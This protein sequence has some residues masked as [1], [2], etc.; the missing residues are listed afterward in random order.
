M[1]HPATL[2]W[3]AHDGGGARCARIAADTYLVRALCSTIPEAL[4]ALAHEAD[5]KSSAY[6]LRH[7]P[8]DEDVELHIA[9]PALAGAVADL[10][11]RVRQRYVVVPGVH[12]DACSVTCPGYWEASLLRRSLLTV[13]HVMACSSVRIAVNTSSHEDCVIAHRCGQIAI[14]GDAIEAQGTISVEGRTVVGQDIVFTSDACVADGDL[15]APIATLQPGEV[16]E[17]DLFFTRGTPL[18]HA[19]FH[20]VASP[21]YEPDVRLSRQPTPEEIE[22]KLGEYTVDKDL[23]CTRR[24]GRPCRVEALREILPHLGAELGPRVRLGVEAL[25]QFPA[26]VCVE[27][28]LGAAAADSRALLDAVRECDRSGEIGAFAS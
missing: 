26:T 15:T 21:S 25:G 28:A 22:E 17:A 11:G 16:L 10:E 18:E 6:C 4:C 12:D 9:L 14:K 1:A 24:D 13:V 20:S 19:K 3:T 27:R 2:D 23:V 8:H 7:H 5:P